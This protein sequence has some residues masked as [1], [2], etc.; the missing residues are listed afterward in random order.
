[1]PKPAF[2]I[3][4]PEK[5]L[6]PEA[7]LTKADVAAYVQRAAPLMWPYVKERLVSLVRCPE[8]VGHGSFFQRHPA[9]GFGKGWGEQDYESAGGKM[10]RYIYAA[11]QAALLEAV[12]MNTLE[13]HLWGSRRDKPDV[14]DRVVFDLDPDT[15]LTFAEVKT[16]ALRLRDVL[17][18]LGLISQPMLTGGKGIHLVIPLHREHEFA[19]VKRFCGDVA[20]RLADD[21]PERFTA[22]MSKAKRQGRVFIDYFRNEA[23]ATAIAPYS[24]RARASAGVA[25]PCRWEELG[26]YDAADAMTIPRAMQALE[27]AVDPWAGAK[28]QTLS[29]TVLRAAA[30]D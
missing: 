26:Q 1:M 25:W 23:G 9:A 15:E 18:A 24:P 7:G 4:H 29:A 6:Y 17:N 11:R 14:P 30:Q 27:N 28:P 21:A 22:T 2:H 13:F 5:Q 20:Q 10:E 3:T 8:G 19:V 16:A 12:Q